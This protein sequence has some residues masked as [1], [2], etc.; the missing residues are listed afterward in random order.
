[1]TITSAFPG[2]KFVFPLSA[3]PSCSCVCRR[4]AN[5]AN[6]HNNP[7]NPSS[8][9]LTGA[10]CLE[11]LSYIFAVW[12]IFFLMW[13]VALT[14]MQVCMNAQPSVRK[15]KQQ[16]T[17]WIASKPTVLLHLPS[18]NASLKALGLSARRPCWGW[19]SV[20]RYPC[21][22]PYSLANSYV[23]PLCGCPLDH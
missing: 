15:E 20:E 23:S 11:T 2:K 7:I 13:S 8:R 5:A 10:Q 12:L 17:I 22:A 21:G 9:R 3:N 18:T 6:Q 19:C 14:I 4:K 16:I 1:M